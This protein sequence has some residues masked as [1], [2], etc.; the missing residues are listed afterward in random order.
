MTGAD[1]RRIKSLIPDPPAR[2]HFVGIGGIGVSGLA[3]ILRGRGYEVSG[4]D[5]VA[6]DVTEGLESEGIPV[7]IGHD[8]ANVSG[9][10][11]VITTAAATDDNVELLAARAEVRPSSSGLSCSAISRGTSAHW[12]W[13]DPMVS[14]RRPGWPLLR[15]T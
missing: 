8:S 14:R 2:L 4:S 7:S 9:A 6:S 1:A 11:V 12:R 5:M 13:Q 3:R 15:S 10:D